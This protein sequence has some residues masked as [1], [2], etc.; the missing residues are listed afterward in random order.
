MGQVPQHVLLQHQ[1]NAVGQLVG[2]Q[3][4]VLPGPAGGQS[5]LAASES[6]AGLRSSSSPSNQL[7]PAQQ[8]QLNMIGNMNSQ[9]A[10][11]N[12]GA[13]LQDESADSA[14]AGTGGP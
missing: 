8:S 13:Q 12:A 11:G 3:P 5:S 2:N 10:A 7:D 14:A 4:S 9:I 6:M 1:Q